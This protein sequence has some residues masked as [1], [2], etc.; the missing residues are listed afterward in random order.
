MN[1]WTRNSPSGRGG[2]GLEVRS[3][4]LNEVVEDGRPIVSCIPSDLC[5]RVNLH[6]HNLGDA[7]A[8]NDDD[9]GTDTAALAAAFLSSLDISDDERIPN[10]GSWNNMCSGNGESGNGKPESATMLGRSWFTAFKLYSP[11]VRLYMI[12]IAQL[13]EQCALSYVR[14]NSLELESLEPCPSEQ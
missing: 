11:T 13:H 5:R 6:R 8:L 3:A 12:M 2:D 7:A 4:A 10:V 1:R 14:R 9:E